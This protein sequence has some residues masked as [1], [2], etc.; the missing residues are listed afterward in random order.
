MIY[1]EVWKVLHQGEQGCDQ[2]EPV[3][4]QRPVLEDGQGLEAVGGGV[5]GVPTDLHGAP[6]LH[7]GLQVKHRYGHYRVSK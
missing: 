6:G 1:L 7:V 4:G 5:A 3:F 2:L